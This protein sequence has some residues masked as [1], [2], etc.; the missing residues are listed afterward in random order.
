MAAFS[1]CTPTLFQIL[2]RRFHRA[3]QIAAMFEQAINRVS[4][5]ARRFHR[6][7]HAGVDGIFAGVRFVVSILARR[8]HRAQ[9]G[10]VLRL[11]AA[12]FT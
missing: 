11:C 3:Q 8:F 2:A 1:F 9:R 4:I 10:Q 7:Q 6:A 5:L 12:A